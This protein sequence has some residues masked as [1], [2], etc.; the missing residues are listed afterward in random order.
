MAKIAPTPTKVPSTVAPT[1]ARPHTLLLEARLPTE[2][3]E[4]TYLFWGGE[5]GASPD[6]V[7]VVFCLQ[8]MVQG[9][10]VAAYRIM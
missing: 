6:V 5:V 2:D 1:Q 7:F 10:V 3:P 4:G 9:A 8:D